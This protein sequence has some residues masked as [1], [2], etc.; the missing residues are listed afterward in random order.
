MKEN[1]KW[2]PLL[3]GSAQLWGKI[4][5]KFDF[6]RPLLGKRWS[7]HSFC[8]KRNFFPSR[9]Q[10]RG[11]EEA[12]FVEKKFTPNFFEIPLP[13]QS[14]PEFTHLSITG[15]HVCRALSKQGHFAHVLLLTCSTVGLRGANSRYLRVHKDFFFKFE[16]TVQSARS[17]T[18]SWLKRGAKEGWE[19]H[20]KNSP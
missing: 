17:S 18:Y 5:A 19:L 11:R 14:K 13:T 15:L 1:S 10:S 4:T 2:R 16:G 8:E 7:H 3:S 20:P 6:F 12:S 9:R